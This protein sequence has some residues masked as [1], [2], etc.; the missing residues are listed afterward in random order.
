MGYL[1]FKTEKISRKE[2]EIYLPGKLTDN[3]R[4][5]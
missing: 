5:L 1:S 4:D 3:I 2:L